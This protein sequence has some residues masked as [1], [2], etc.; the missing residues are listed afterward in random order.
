MD[1]LLLFGLI[2][3]LPF[4]LLFRFIF[5]E[6]FTQIAIFFYNPDTRIGLIVTILFLYL[7]LKYHKKH[8]K[9][10]YDYLEDL[11]LI[12]GRV[13]AQTYHFNYYIDTKEGANFTVFVDG[14]CGYDFMLKFENRFEKFLK[15][16]SLAYECQS[17]DKH[18]DDTIYILSDDK[19]LCDDL[20]SD[21]LLRKT[22]FKLFWFL[23]IKGYKVKF[24]RYYDGRLILNAIYNGKVDDDTYKEI[25][26]LSKES[27][28]LMQKIIA[29]LPDKVKQNNRI[30]REKTS[31]A[32]NVIIALFS[33]LIF[34]GSVKL[35]ID[36]WDSFFLPRL[37]D[38]YAFIVP[39]L[40]ITALFLALYSLFCFFYFYKSSRL[41]LALFIGLTL[42][43]AGV[44]LTA[45]T[46]LKE[47]NIYLDNSQ[48]YTRVE[49]VTHKYAR[50]GRNTAWFVTFSKLG[51]IRV[52]PSFY[53]SIN[54]KN[55]FVTIQIKKGYLNVPWIY[56][57]KNIKRNK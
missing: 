9:R 3:F 38:R 11:S 25:E 5:P 48:P 28:S 16:I 46:G 55:D 50:K 12:E 40:E 1:V 35:F 29:Q 13:N 34:N 15:K 31:W 6:Q 49:Q 20:K 2:T 19:L 10:K 14:K 21:D 52:P 37:L 7:W 42:G 51:E 4:F 27:A 43:S 53:H 26:A 33:A 47:I 39:S 56:K 17:E 30:Y 57:I 32:I 23:K 54:I 24:L 22:I 36:S 18:F 44:F 41:A 45:V 8:K